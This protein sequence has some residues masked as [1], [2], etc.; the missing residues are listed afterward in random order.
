MYY[1]YVLRSIYHDHLYKGHCNNLKKRITE[2]NS[3]M[4]RSIRAF[5][6]YELVYFESFEEEAQAIAREKYF[7][8]AAGRRY[9]KKVLQK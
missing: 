5:I 1:S 8:S 3:G 4:T 9:L 2:H 7:K 6:P